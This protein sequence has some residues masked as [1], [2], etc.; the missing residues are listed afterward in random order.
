MTSADSIRG[1]KGVVLDAILTSVSLKVALVGAV[2]AAL[3]LVIRDGVIPAFMVIWGT[4]FFLGGV[5]VYAAIWV[6]KPD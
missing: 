4:A 5:L 2:L 1:S 6:K 3:G